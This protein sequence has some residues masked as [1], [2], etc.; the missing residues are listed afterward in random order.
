MRTATV[1]NFLIEATLAGSVMILLML[2]V[3]RFLR[4]K[5]TSR[6]LCFAW[7]LVALRLLLPVSLPNPMMNELRPAFSEDFGVRPIAEQVRVRS[8][9]AV[10]ELAMTVE[11]QGGTEAAGLADDLWAART[12]I[13]NG[14][15]AERLLAAYAAGALAVAGWMTWRNMRFLLA[16]RRGRVEALGGER[17]ARY[18]ELCKRRGVRPLPVYWVDPLPSAC[19]AGVFRPYIA[20]PLLLKDEDF[21]AVLTHELCH[22]KAGD[23][24][25]GLVR[26]LCCV[27]HWF[28]PLVWLAARLSRSDQEMACDERVIRP[29]NDEERIRYAS[30]LAQNAARRCAPETVVLATGMTMKGRHI[31]RRVRAIVD[32]RAALRWLCAAAL[33]VSCAGTL[34]AFATSELHQPLAEPVIPQWEGP[35]LERRAVTTPQEAETYAKELLSSASWLNAGS[36]R[37]DELEWQVLKGE[38]AGMW[39]VHVWPPQGEEGGLF[40]LG[41]DTEGRIWEVEDMAATDALNRN[42]TPANPSYTSDDEYSAIIFDFAHRFADQVLGEGF[43]TLA[44]AGDAWRGGERCVTL[45]YTMAQT[46]CEGTLS[47]QMSP[48][49]RVFQLSRRK[50]GADD[51]ERIQASNAAWEVRQ[52]TLLDRALEGAQGVEADFRPL[53]EV[54]PETKELAN[55]AYEALV[56]TFGYSFADAERFVYAAMEQDATMFLI[57]HDAAYPEWNYVMMPFDEAR[58]PFTSRQGS[59]AK[60]EGIRFLWYRVEEEGWFVRWQAEDRD[61]FVRNAI[62][63]RYEIPFTDVKKADIRAGLLSV[64]QTIQATFEAYY[65]PES[66]WSDALCSWR[67]ATLMRFDPQ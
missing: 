64:A 32:G 8:A 62:D 61:A 14:R 47:I 30:A 44:I 22:K 33:A 55:Q 1:F 50:S 2:P 46:G 31:K 34:F 3:R 60:E 40:T 13:R 12:D 11:A 15:M 29:M 6:L 39:H 41:F 51:V 28:N 21:L 35:A 7:L 67:D 38:E 42:K 4:S 20:L 66:Q 45:S 65:G 48:Q 37:L 59:H 5:L 26:N 58:T 27:I 24:W 19:L 49:M 23:P 54:D 18:R 9:D 63:Y 43:D 17:L 52:E 25:W 53:A 57:F 56:G 16:L 10:V 36:H